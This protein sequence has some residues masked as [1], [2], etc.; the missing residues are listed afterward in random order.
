MT[1]DVT[2]ENERLRELSASGVAVWFDGL[3]REHIETGDFQRLVDEYAVVGTVTD[4]PT[5]AAAIANGDYDTRL[6]QLA[7]E[8]A[9]EDTS[10]LDIMVSDARQAC[11]ILAAT[12]ERTGGLDGRVVIPIDPRQAD[13][14]DA[15]VER[16]RSLWR[17]VDR[18]NA[19]VSLPATE[20]C[21]SAITTC[22]SEGI[23]VDISPLFSR[24]RYRAFSDAYAAGLERRLDAGE[25]L[26]GI[27]SLAGIPIRDVDVEVNQRL[28]FN[29][30][31][32]AL[33][34]RGKIAIAHGRLM[35][36]EY[37]DIVATDRWRKLAEA[38]AAPQRPRFSATEP[39]SPEWIDTMYVTE[40]VASGLVT[41]MN[42]RTLLAFADH[43]EV[44]G[45][46][47]HDNYWCQEMFNRLRRAGP[48]FEE[49]VESLEAAGLAALQSAWSDLS[50][51][52][53]E[54]LQALT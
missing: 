1:D 17:A 42:A 11:D 49:A 23:S 15:M 48:D 53:S 9:H 29:G 43:G 8:G 50:G 7:A 21:L 32:R 6:R 5:L 14:A 39:V 44:H 36:W 30:M 2:T 46:T 16:A 51:A 18:P 20:Q 26:T 28:E 54:R 19:V 25:P 22:V 10:L 37:E 33:V 31:E 3:I 34:L 24:D 35:F 13:D 4:T 52:V 45:D 41:T 27:V 12:A 38:G 47:V 40:L